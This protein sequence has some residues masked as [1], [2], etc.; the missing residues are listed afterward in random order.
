MPLACTKALLREICPPGLRRAYRALFQWRWFR[1]RYASWSEAQAHAGS[2]DEPAILAKVLRATL[3]V[4]AGRAAYERD[5]VLFH[6]PAPDDSLLA[7]LMQVAAENGGRLRV[8]DFGGSLGTTYW[9]HRR[10]LGRLPELRWSVV[11]QSHFVAAGRQHL[12]DET[13][14][15]HLTLD[16]AEQAAPHDVLL[17][18][19][20]IQCLPD[21]HAFLADCV[22]RRPL[23]ILLHNVPLHRGEPDHLRIEHVPPEIYSA[24]YPF[25]FFNEA[26]IMAH[27]AGQYQVEHRYASPAIWWIGMRDYA[28]TG[29]RLRRLGGPR[30]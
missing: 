13:L 15:F 6:E 7:G 4:K 8:L 3:E 23:A 24:T 1:G 30:A 19:G 26:G 18:S 5:A 25:W 29:L 11:E 27:F 9:Q 22:R 28:S 21:P 16:E 20:V 17:L 10:E 2:Y 14:R 12:Q